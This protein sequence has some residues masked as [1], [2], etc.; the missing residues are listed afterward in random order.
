MR[1]SRIPEK[2][3]DRKIH[4]NRHVAAAGNESRPGNTRINESRSMAVN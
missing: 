4:I 3:I 2:Y 1:F